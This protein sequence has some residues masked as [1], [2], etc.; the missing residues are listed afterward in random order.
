MGFLLA[1]Y[2]LTCLKPDIAQQAGLSGV[3]LSDKG[4]TVR[5]IQMQNK[6]PDLSEQHHTDVRQ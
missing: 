2:R 1:L 6:H 5:L 4:K 3:W